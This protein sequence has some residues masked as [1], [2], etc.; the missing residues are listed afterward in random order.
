MNSRYTVTKPPQIAICDCAFLA[1]RSM[2]VIIITMITIIHMIIVICNKY[3]IQ[4]LK[5]AEQYFWQQI[6]NCNK[7]NIN[8]TQTQ[9]KHKMLKYNRKA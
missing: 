9:M 1:F 7:N 2:G 8:N 4:Q 5:M 3:E 6:K